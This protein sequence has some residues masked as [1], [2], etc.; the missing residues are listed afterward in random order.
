MEIKAL[1]YIGLSVSDP[2]AW[3]TFATEDLG[4][5]AHDR[6]D[7]GFDLRLDS[8]AWRIRIQPGE[9]DDIAFAGWEVASA[10]DLEALAHRLSE[11]GVEVERGGAELCADRQVAGLIQFADPDGL[12]CEA[13]YGP[14]QL[15]Q[16]P[17]ASPRG[18]SF[19]TGDQGLGH[20]V[21]ATREKTR[22]ADFYE[23]LLGFK[24][25]D[26]IHTEILPGRPLSLSFYRCNGRHHSLAIAPLPIPKK[27]V[28]F[29]LETT[30]VDDVGRAMY[31]VLDK[32]RH[33][34]FTLG[35]HSNDEML[36]FYVMTPSGFDLEYGW[37]GL[38]VDDDTWHVK[39]HNVNS[40]W[41]HKFQRPPKPGS[42]T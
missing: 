38:A 3:K 17:F 21:L 26:H 36:S 19:R 11:A 24:L 30:S 27:L 6:S 32:G 33:L 23:T 31:R 29:M 35:R 22:L 15:T 16:T 34:S 39:T 40:A 14:L 18:V 8:Y 13:F 20:I 28:H 37:G 5:T 10:A 2:Q 41:G 7:G 1:G 25:S 12:T 42:E 9:P 4:L